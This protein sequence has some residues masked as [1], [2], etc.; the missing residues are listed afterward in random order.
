MIVIIEIESIAN[1]QILPVNLI[2]FSIGIPL[3]D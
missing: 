2:D 3:V 1:S